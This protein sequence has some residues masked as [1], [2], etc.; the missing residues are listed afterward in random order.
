MRDYDE[1]PELTCEDCDLYRDGKR[2]I[3]VC[4]KEGRDV[5]EL[6]FVWGDNEACREFQ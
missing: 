6:I 2:G 4:C 5:D 1:E 3:G